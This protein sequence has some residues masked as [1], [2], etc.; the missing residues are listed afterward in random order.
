LQAFH[1]SGNGQG[2]RRLNLRATPASVRRDETMVKGFKRV[3]VFCGSSK[4]CRPVYSEAANAVGTLLARQGIGMVFGGGRR[5]LMGVAADAALAAGGEV[6][7][8]IPR[9]LAELEVEH[10]GVTRLHV[11]E[12]MHERKALMAGLSDA[13]LALPGG[14]GTI[15]EFCEV[16]TWSQLGVHCKPCGLLNTEGYFDS[17]LSFFDRSVAEG[18]LKAEHRGLV[19]DS[20]DPEQLLQQLAEFQIPILEKW[21]T[22]EQA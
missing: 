5:G 13:F 7:G 3:C 16:V 8:V 11:V 9:A 10:R 17:L 19:L 4:G 14:Y 15:E 22:E 2:A 1:I 21:I 20:S 12:T 18:F 6:I